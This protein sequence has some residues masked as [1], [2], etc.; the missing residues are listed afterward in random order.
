MHGIVHMTSIRP[1]QLCL[2]LQ[3]RPKTKTGPSKTRRPTG[4]STGRSAVLSA[5]QS[6]EPSEGDGPSEADAEDAD[7]DNTNELNAS[8]EEEDQD[9]S[10]KCAHAYCHGHATDLHISC[11]KL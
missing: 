3:A 4:R 2:L 6:V 11:F 8:D 5:S 7:S 9:L 10:E 1:R